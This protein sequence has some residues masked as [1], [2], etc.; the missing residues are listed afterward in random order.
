MKERQRS[1]DFWWLLVTE[2]QRR[3]S[4]SHAAGVGVTEQLYQGAVIVNFLITSSDIHRFPILLIAASIS[5]QDR[6]L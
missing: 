5:F 4:G 3:P 6:F 2:K 1:L